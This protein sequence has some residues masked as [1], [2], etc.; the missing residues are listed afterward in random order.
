[1]SKWKMLFGYIFMALTLFMLWYIESSLYFSRGWVLYYWPTYNYISL[2]TGAILSKF[3][4]IPG[5]LLPE[6][7]CKRAYVLNVIHSF[8]E[9]FSCL[10]RCVKCLAPVCIHAVLTRDVKMHWWFMMCH[11]L[12]MKIHQYKLLTVFNV[13]FAKSLVFRLVKSTK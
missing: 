8:S 1:M 11:A 5:L 4:K 10:E 2:F 12:T 3:Y 13:L 7:F 9:N 6:I